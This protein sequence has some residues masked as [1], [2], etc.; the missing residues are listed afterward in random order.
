MGSPPAAH[1]F[2]RTC[3]TAT[4]PNRTVGL[5]CHDVDSDGFCRDQDCDDKDPT[6]ATG[7][8]D[9]DS[10]GLSPCDGDCDDAN[11]LCDTDCTDGDG[12]TDIA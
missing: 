7:C 8:D 2:A 10:D 5:D 4:T 3:S 6:C 11:P 12:G 1:P 9:V